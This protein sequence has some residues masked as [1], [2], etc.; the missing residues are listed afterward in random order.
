MSLR[1]NPAWALLAM[2][3]LLAACGD[4]S[5]GP[6]GATAEFRALHATPNLGPID[7]LVGGTPVVNGLPYGATSPAVTVPGG[8]QRFVVRA[9]N[10]VLADLQHVLST[11]HVNS[12]VISDSAP[13]F[14]EVVVPDT[15]QTAPAFAHLR[16][17]NVVGSNTSPPTLLD[18]LIR[19]PGPDPDS[20]VTSTLD[21]TVPAYWSLMYFPPGEFNVRYV[22][23]G[24]TT[25][26]TEV[27]FDVAAG[28]KKAVVLG[29]SDDGTY[30][31]EVVTEP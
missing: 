2:T 9:G 16:L 3:S 24:E 4:S 30:H 26:L 29:R 6:G 27:T 22:P 8:Q 10:Q 20:I 23:T 19:W 25:V 5:N 12:L 13:Q 14:S 28:E 15:G 31:A 7:V 21:A 1:T 18:I 11:A 17:V